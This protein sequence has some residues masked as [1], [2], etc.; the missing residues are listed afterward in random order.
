MCTGAKS[1][2]QILEGTRKYAKIIK[3]LGFDIT[4]QEFQI[5]NMV[6]SFDFKKPIKLDEFMKNERHK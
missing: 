6:A 5:Q 2:Q 4:F 1:E 3:Q